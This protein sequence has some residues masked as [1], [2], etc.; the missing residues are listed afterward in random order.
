M[1]IFFFQ[2]YRE[3]RYRVQYQ[4]LWYEQFQY[5]LLIWRLHR[6]SHSDWAFGSFLLD[7]E[8]KWAENRFFSI[9][10]NYSCSK[11]IMGHKVS[12]RFI[13][14]PAGFVLINRKKSFKFMS[15]LNSSRMKLYVYADSL[16]SLTN[17][18]L[19]CIFLQR[20]NRKHES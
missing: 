8:R 4:S 7:E 13:M 15:V 2:C 19:V 12:C 18:Q 16:L 20:C 9:R 11:G 6:G 14:S 5:V 17:R 3:V 10:Q 1:L